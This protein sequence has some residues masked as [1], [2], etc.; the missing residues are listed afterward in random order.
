[1]TTACF[2]CGK[3]TEPTT[4]F[5]I[6]YK[7]YYEYRDYPAHK[8]N[9]NLRTRPIWRTFRTIMAHSQRCAEEQWGDIGSDLNWTHRMKELDWRVRQEKEL[10]HPNVVAG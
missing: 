1:M 4:K 10:E 7:D 5:V 2:Y 8:D 9:Y 3:T 6:E